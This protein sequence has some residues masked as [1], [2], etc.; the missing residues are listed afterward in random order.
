MSDQEVLTF[1][2][3]ARA[4]SPGNV[5]ISVLVWLVHYPRWP[6]LLFAMLV[7]SLVL[8]LRAPFAGL[9]VAGFLILPNWLYW[10]RIKEHFL[11][12]DANPGLIVSVDPMLYAVGTDLT[13]GEGR[14]PVVKVV[15]KRFRPVC[16]PATVGARIMTVALYQASAEPEDVALPHWVGFDPRPIDCATRDR[17][18]IDKALASVDDQR[19][20]WLQAALEEVPQPYR[21]GIYPVERSTSSWAQVPSVGRLRS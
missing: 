2:S 1:D 8:V 3:S 14:F 4:S 16:S 17:D 11:H 6:L 13:K 9:M 10:R 21:P 5:S 12:G 7:A 18:Q 15:R 20:A 19:W